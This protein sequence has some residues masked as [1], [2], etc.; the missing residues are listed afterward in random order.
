MNNLLQKNGKFILLTF[1]NPFICGLAP[2]DSYNMNLLSMDYSL[3]WMKYCFTT[4]HTA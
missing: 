1:F 2:F 4:A 3:L